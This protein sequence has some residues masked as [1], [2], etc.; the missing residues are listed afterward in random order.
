MSNNYTLS[1]IEDSLVLQVFNL[2]GEYENKQTLRAVMSKID[3][4]FPNFVVDLSKIEFMNSV[5][6]NF[7]ISLKK[8]SKA[9]GSQLALANVS[10]KIIQLL[11]ITKLRPM[12]F[13]TNSVEE[14]LQAFSAYEG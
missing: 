12:F 4:G 8:Q 14:A 11:E 1:T 2:R 10:Q 7:L 9:S 6:L 13:I 3:G 5:G